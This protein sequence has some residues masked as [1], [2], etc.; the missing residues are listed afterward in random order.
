MAGQLDAAANRY[1]AIEQLTEHQETIQWYAKEMVIQRAIIHK[2]QNSDL[3]TA[4]DTYTKLQQSRTFLLQTLSK[5]RLCLMEAELYQLAK[6]AGQIYTG[7]SRF[8]LMSNNYKPVY[9]LLYGFAE[10]FPTNATANA[11]VIGRLMNRVKMGY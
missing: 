1:Y 2:Y 4:R 8:D 3:K 5:V 9:D 7:L 11:A 10:Q 6:T